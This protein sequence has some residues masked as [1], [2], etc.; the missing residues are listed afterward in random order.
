[1]RGFGA[2][3]VCFAHE[4]QMD[5]LAGELGMDP[6]ELR[7]KNAIEPGM[8]FPFG[9]EV[10]HPAPVREILDRVKAMPMPDEREAMG[11]DLRELPGGVSNV[12]HGE[13][14][15]RGVGYAVGFKNIGFSAGFDDYS[16][17]RVILTVEDGEPLAQVHTAAAEVGQ[18]GVMVQAQIA[19]TELGVER[20]AILPSDTRVGSAGST[21]A[22]RQ[23][24]MTGGAV[25]MACEAVRE[26]VFALAAREMDED[27][28]DLSMENGMMVSGG[29][30]VIPLADLLDG[31][32]VEETVEFHHKETHPLDENG[33]GDAHLQFAFA[34]HRAVVEVD[35]ELGLVRVVEIATAQDVGK[36]MNPQALE[37]QIEGGI[38]QG[39]GLALMEE[40]QVSEGKVQNASFTDY[41]I[42]TIL[43]MPPVRMDILE[44]AD[45]EAPYGLKGVGEPPTISSTPAIVAALRDA[46]GCELTRVPVKP[47]Q[48][49]GISEGQRGE[50]TQRED[51]GYSEVGRLGKRREH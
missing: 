39:L 40:I 44:L 7:V 8:K 26:Q 17:A 22:S 14:V 12:T 16:T 11:R 37:G 46:T 5:K 28:E 20:V 32:E 45:P 25:K 10:P 48:I 42:P 36:I 4:S 38:A 18:G 6:V 49:A 47:E 33:Q 29:R 50:P 9:Q 1:M 43:D 34:A 31:E 21:S 30:V 13:G 15:K 27:A 3:Q 2:V 41:L 23:T 24:Y 35:T 19:R 51:A